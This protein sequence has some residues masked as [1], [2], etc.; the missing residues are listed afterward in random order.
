VV[1]GMGSFKCR[2]SRPGALLQAGMRPRPW[3]SIPRG[4]CRSIH[5]QMHNLL[6]SARLRRSGASSTFTG[7]WLARMRVSG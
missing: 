5:A 7:H 1:L 6:S 4:Y 2:N 3:R